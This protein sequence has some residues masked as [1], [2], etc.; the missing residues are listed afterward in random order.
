MF[1][2]RVGDG[3]P[4][5]DKPAAD[6]QRETL[7][8]TFDL[9]AHNQIMGG[10]AA[11]LAAFPVGDYRLEVKLTDRAAQTKTAGTLDFSVFGQ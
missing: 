7:P 9:A 4:V 6:L 2:Q 8:A 5:Q 10:L 3:E 11:P 1:Y